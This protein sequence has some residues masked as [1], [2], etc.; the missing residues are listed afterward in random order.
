MAAPGKSRSLCPRRSSRAGKSSGCSHLPCE[1]TSLAHA[2]KKTV[3]SRVGSRMEGGL[4]NMTPFTPCCRRNRLFEGVLKR[5]P[6]WTTPIDAFKK[7]PSPSALQLLERGSIT[8]SKNGQV[9]LD[10]C[11]NQGPPQTFFLQGT[12][13]L[14]LVHHHLARPKSMTQ[15]SLTPTSKPAR[16]PITFFVTRFLSGLVKTSPFH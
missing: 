12:S 6:I 3:R 10:M 4:R 16:L 2:E 14:T 9:T 5:A 7:Q 13:S 15:G 8:L 1:P 11:Q